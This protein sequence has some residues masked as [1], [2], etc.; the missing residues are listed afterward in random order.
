[1]NVTNRETAQKG[2]NV[3]L[4]WVLAQGFF[5]FVQLVAYRVLS[6]HHERV[7]ALFTLVW[8][9]VA[10]AMAVGLIVIATA[11]DRPGLIWATVGFAVFSE[12]LSLGL[13]VG[14][15]LIENGSRFWIMPISTANMLMS[16]VE[17]GLLLFVLL[18]LCG[19]KRTWALM[20][21]LVAAGVLVLRLSVGLALSLG[22]AA[23]TSIMDWY[24]YLTGFF[25]LV[26]VGC[27]LALVLGVRAALAEA[28][29]GEGA[30]TPAV[31]PVE[32]PVSPVADFGIGA[33]LLIGGIVVTVVSYSLASSS[34][35]GRYVVATGL[36][37]VGLGRV[38]RGFIRLG[39]Q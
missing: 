39:K 31:A 18:K 9:G 27:T 3:L 23:Y 16:L 34:S 17:R 15:R 4:G 24:P 36:I 28:P 32:A 8:L 37:G 22:L 14:M 38:I 26:G 2:A 33:A 13:T 19:P 10:V 25:S 6:E 29:A 12:V 11:V 30:A 20:V 21:A 5:S 1:M 35:G 7:S